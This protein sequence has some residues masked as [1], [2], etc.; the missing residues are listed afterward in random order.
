MRGVSTHVYGEAAGERDYLACTSTASSS[1]ATRYWRRW[2][3]RKG[4]RGILGIREGASEDAAAA[5][6]LR[7]ELVVGS[8]DDVPCA[9]TPQRGALR[10]AVC[11]SWAL[12]SALIFD[13]L[14]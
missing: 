4:K 12:Y 8:K 3:W 1:P 11:S 7:E 10:S 9:W 5:L 6:A 2:A 13:T 14:L